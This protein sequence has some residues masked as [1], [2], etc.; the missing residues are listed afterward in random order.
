MLGCCKTVEFHIYFSI[1]YKIAFTWDEVF[2]NAPHWHRWSIN[3]T[4]I[5]YYWTMIGFVRLHVVLEQVRKCEINR[6]GNHVHYYYWYIYVCILS[7]CCALFALQVDDDEEEMAKKKPTRFDFGDGDF[8]V[9]DVQY[10]KDVEIKSLKALPLDEK[11]IWQ[12]LIACEGSL[13][14]FSVV[15][16]YCPFSSL[17]LYTLIVPSLLSF[18]PLSL[19][20]LFSPLIHSH[21][22]FS[23]LFLSTLIV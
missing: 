3:T 8:V 23:S 14:L 18:N 2:S 11:A 21:Y 20:L 7:H 22:P 5:G 9:K 1:P 15:H 17:L 13:L 19:P 10:W 6:K 4:S 12:V 16:S